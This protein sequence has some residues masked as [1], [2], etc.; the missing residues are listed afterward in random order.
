M[1]NSNISISIAITCPA[2]TAPPHGQV[3]PEE[4]QN[5]PGFRVTCQFLCGGGYLLSGSNIRTCL[6][7]GDWNDNS[8]VSCKGIGLNI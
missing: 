4:C 2:L 3:V 1:V 5:S 8:D 6:S 7:K